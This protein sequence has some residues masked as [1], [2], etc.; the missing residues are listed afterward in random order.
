MY[1]AEGRD[2]QLRCAQAPEKKIDDEDRA[3]LGR[4]IDDQR[5]CE[6]P[7]AGKRLLGPSRGW[8]LQ[9]MPPSEGPG[10]DSLGRHTDH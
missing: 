7:V 5:P 6:T 2:G 10:E 8:Q 1:D 3:E 9:Q 4:G